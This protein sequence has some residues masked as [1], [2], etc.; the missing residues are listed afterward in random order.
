[1]VGESILQLEFTVDKPALNNLGLALITIKW[2]LMEKLAV[3]TYKSVFH[4]SL[5]KASMYIIFTYNL[6]WDP[7]YPI[8]LKF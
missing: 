6:L 7:G 4:G 3:S 5:T 8:M 1:M 2:I